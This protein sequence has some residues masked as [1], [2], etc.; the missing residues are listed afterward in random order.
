MAFFIEK[1]PLVTE[2]GSLSASSVYPIKDLIACKVIAYI[3]DLSGGALFGLPP[4]IHGT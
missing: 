2:D 1:R 4:K 3:E